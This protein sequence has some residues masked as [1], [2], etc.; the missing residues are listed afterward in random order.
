MRLQKEELAVVVLL[1]FAALAACVLVL[2][3]GESPGSKYTGS[4]KTGDTVVLEG[5]LVHKEKTGSGGHMLLTVKAGT[6]LVTVFV[7]ARGSAI[8]IAT[9][10]TSGNMLSVRGKV[11]DYKGTREVVASSISIE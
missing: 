9:S 5:L 1:L 2:V 11:Q 4:S 7:D 8:D 6:E 10:A 3:T